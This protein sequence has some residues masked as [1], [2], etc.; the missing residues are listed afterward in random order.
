LK[1]ELEEFLFDEAEQA[2][3]DVAMATSKPWD[4]D[5]VAAI[6]KRIKDFHLK[7]NEDVCC[8]CQRDLQGEFQMVID[9]E[10]ILPT[11]KF[12]GQTFK[13]WNLS[14]SCKRCNLYIKKADA[15]FINNGSPFEESATYKFAHPN[16]DD[17]ESHVIRVVQQIGKSRIVKYFIATPDK[18]QYTYDYFKFSELETDSFDKAQGAS[19][20]ASAHPQEFETMWNRVAALHADT[21]SNSNP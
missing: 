11:T 12:K 17:P 19:R 3:I 9:V 14:A 5:D 13:I 10:H 4:H 2:L 16:F 1:A 8:Y 21:A 15:S 6:R 7:L 20:K 18:G